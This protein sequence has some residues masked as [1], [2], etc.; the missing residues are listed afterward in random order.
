[1]TFTS[2]SR[3]ANIA[4]SSTAIWRHLGSPWALL[5]ALFVFAAITPGAR[6]QLVISN[7]IITPTSLSF[8]LSGTVTGTASGSA[9]QLRIAPDQVVNMVATDKYFATGAGSSLQIGSAE[10]YRVD[11]QTSINGIVMYFDADVI[12]GDAASGTVSY[13]F[14]ANTFQNLTG[15]TFRLYRGYNATESTI[16]LTGIGAAA[17]PEPSTYAAL[18]GVLGLAAAGSRRSRRRRA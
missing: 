2:L 5:T 7:F 3:R 10:L 9:S 12:T 8:T 17:V 16:Q 18:C 11:A 6:A 1:M 13:T 14:P 15:T 4:Y